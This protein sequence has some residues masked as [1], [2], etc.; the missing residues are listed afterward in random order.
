MKSIVIIFSLIPLAFCSSSSKTG[1][2][3]KTGGDSLITEKGIMIFSKLR[4]DYFFPALQQSIIN[5]SNY[6]QMPY[7]QGFVLANLGT[8]PRIDLIKNFSDTLTNKRN[9]PLTHAVPVIIEYYQMEK[10][11]NPSSDTLCFM[12]SSDTNCLAFDAK[13]R[14]IKKVTPIK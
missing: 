10:S 8:D 5:K 11:S 14:L 12:L 1:K 7:S 6:K 3:T 4:I 13:L 2:L 9:Y